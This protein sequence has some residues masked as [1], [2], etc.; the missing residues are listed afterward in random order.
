MHDGKIWPNG[1]R[2]SFH[3]R[4]GRDDD[5]EP[6]RGYQGVVI[7]YTTD[8]FYRV[9]WDSPNPKPQLFN[10]GTVFHPDDLRQVSA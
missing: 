4:F 8:G 9:N 6:H 2:V 5:E 10:L 3:P 1:T 7:C